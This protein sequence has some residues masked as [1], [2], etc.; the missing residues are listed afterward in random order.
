MRF[1]KKLLEEVDNFNVPACDTAE[2]G[3]A[4]RDLGG[5]RALLGPGRGAPRD[6]GAARRRRG[7]DDPPLGERFALR[8]GID[9]TKNNAFSQR[10]MHF[11]DGK[12]I[13]DTYKSRRV[14]NFRRM[15]RTDREKYTNFV[16]K[17]TFFA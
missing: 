11:R 14:H 2:V 13:F 6:A 16:A 3:A 7:G 4:H 15:T 1:L 8:E 10:K 5:G 9:R 17:I 12:C